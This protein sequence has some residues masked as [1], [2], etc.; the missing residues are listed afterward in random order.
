MK[1]F[2]F[3]IF[4]YL[5][6]FGVGN[7]PVIKKNSDRYCARLKDGVLVVMFQGNVLTSDVTLDNGTTIKTD[8]TVIKK[9]G[10]TI[11]LKEDEC[12]DKEG[13]ITKE[14]PKEKEKYKINLEK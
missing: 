14:N 11:T 6:S 9:D 7:G 12:I 13:K 8:G 4:V 5:F 1:T 2:L 10:N 3:S